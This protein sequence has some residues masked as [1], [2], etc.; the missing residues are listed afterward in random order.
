MSRS[1]FVKN[2]KAGSVPSFYGCTFNNLTGQA[3]AFTK[4]RQGK[5]QGGNR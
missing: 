1:C 5:R 2:N 4:K 3:K